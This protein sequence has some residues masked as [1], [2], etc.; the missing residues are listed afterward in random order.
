VHDAGQAD[1]T[2]SKE[3]NKKQWNLKGSPLLSFTPKEEMNRL[4][5]RK[6]SRRI[7]T[8][9]LSYWA[10]YC[11]CNSSFFFTDLPIN[12]YESAKNRE[13]IRPKKT[14][15]VTLPNKM[16]LL[17]DTVLFEDHILAKAEAADFAPT[18][19]LSRSAF[20]TY[21]Q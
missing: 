2:V 16:D 20:V 11:F 12:P 15:N 9:Y 3:N 17:L 1:T 14:A 18:H 5:Y 8:D 4:E 10:L 19:R 21:Q 6:T 7:S 13:I